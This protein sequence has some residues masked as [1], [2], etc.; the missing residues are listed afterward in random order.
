VCD[1]RRNRRAR[2]RLSG[3]RLAIVVDEGDRD[4]PLRPEMAPLVVEVCGGGGEEE[5]FVVFL[6]QTSRTGLLS[7][8]SD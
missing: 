2:R 5:E 7:T 6:A 1:H 4:V 8:R 3:D